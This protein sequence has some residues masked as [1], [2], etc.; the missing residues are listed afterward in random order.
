M[1]PATAHDLGEG[2]T[3][4]LAHDTVRRADREHA[5]REPTSTVRRLRHTMPNMATTKD[6]LGQA[7]E[8][9]RPDRA[10]LARDLIASLDEPLDPAQDVE[11]AW[12]AEIERRVAD[13][14][15]GVARTIPWDEARKQIVERLRQR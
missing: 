2:D 4:R 11:T 6:L 7:L 5:C 8:L 3:H 10:T 14:D 15:A 12:F 13:L 1:L 9:S